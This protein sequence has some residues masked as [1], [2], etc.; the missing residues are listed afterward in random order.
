MNAGIANN[1]DAAVANGPLAK[2]GL[3]F[4]NLNIPY[5]IVGYDGKYKSGVL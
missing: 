1:I 3:S 4:L 2:D 5:A